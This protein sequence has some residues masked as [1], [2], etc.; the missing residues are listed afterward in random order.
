MKKSIAHCFVDG[1]PQNS[2]MF[3]SLHA[4]GG[5]TETEV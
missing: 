5:F 2:S 1:L 3:S 4:E